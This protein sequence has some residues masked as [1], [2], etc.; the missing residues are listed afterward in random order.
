M[1][2]VL[3]NL[4]VDEICIEKLDNLFKFIWL[5]NSGTGSLFIYN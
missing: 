5:E 2:R 4:L 1:L 3:Y